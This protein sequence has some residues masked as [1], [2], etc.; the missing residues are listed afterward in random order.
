MIGQEPVRRGR[1]GRF[2]DQIARLNAGAG[3][4]TVSTNEKTVYAVGVG[5][6]GVPSSRYGVALPDT[7]NLCLSWQRIK[8]RLGAVSNLIEQTEQ[9]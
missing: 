4:K 6:I 8:R 2:A 9:Q 7:P 3:S 1:A 5:G